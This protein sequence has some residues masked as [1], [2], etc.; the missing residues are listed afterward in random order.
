VLGAV[1]TAALLFGY[2]AM[3]DHI[4]KVISQHID[5]RSTVRGVA[6][7]KELPKEDG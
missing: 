6:P 1:L 5:Q 3:T 7:S 4:A 2:N